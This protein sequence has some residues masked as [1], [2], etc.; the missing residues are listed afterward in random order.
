MI[1]LD[2]P[3][4]LRA[5]FAFALHPKTGMLVF[6]YFIHAIN[7]V[8]VGH[9]LDDVEARFGLPRLDKEYSVYATVPV[10]RPL[11]NFPGAPAS[12]EALLDNVFMA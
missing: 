12:R 11:I 2:L 8:R 3:P 1:D 7:T 5:K 9:V 10:M 6:P 4:A